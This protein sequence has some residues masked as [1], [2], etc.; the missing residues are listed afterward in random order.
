M[1][2]HMQIDEA[3]F[4]FFFLIKNIINILFS[5]Q[6]LSYRVGVQWKQKHLTQYWPQYL[7][8]QP[9]CQEWLDF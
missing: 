1:H 2:T 4:L 6:L 7:I 9:I 3:K 5:T 8:V